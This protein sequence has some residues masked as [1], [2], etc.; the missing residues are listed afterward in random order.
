MSS[1]TLLLV[2][3]AFALGLWLGFDPEAH[4]ATEDAW[5][6]FKTSV[7][8]FTDQSQRSTDERADLPFIPNTGKD[9]TPDEDAG[10]NQLLDQI[11]A[12]LTELWE[13]IKTLWS[14]LVERTARETAE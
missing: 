12:V 4:A 5:Q 7:R 14:D 2:L 6:D 3:L 9:R 11:S 13:S 10:A 1:S 8:E